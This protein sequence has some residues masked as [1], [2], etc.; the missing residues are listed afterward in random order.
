MWS[1]FVVSVASDAFAGSLLS[2]FFL[3]FTAFFEHLNRVSFG[4]IAISAILSVILAAFVSDTDVILSVCTLLIPTLG[5]TFGA[6]N[7][8]SSTVFQIA[9]V[10]ASGAVIW[11]RIF[12][13]GAAILRLVGT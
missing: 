6:P 1:R 12:A 11:G 9:L 4:S 13:L 10:S 7:A 8:T 2:L 3:S 5:V